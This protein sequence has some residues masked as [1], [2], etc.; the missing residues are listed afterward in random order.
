MVCLCVFNSF[1]RHHP[2]ASG[3]WRR[4]PGI[5]YCRFSIIQRSLFLL[6]LQVQARNLKRQVGCY[7]YAGIIFYFFHFFISCAKPA[8]QIVYLYGP[9][10]DIACQKVIYSLQHTHLFG[11]IKIRGNLVNIVLGFFNFIPDSG[12]FRLIYIQFSLRQG[13]LF[14]SDLAL[15]F[16]YIILPGGKDRC[17]VS[18]AVSR[19]LTC[20]S[21]TAVSSLAS[22]SPFL[23]DRLSVTGISATVPATSKAMSCVCARA[24]LPVP[25]HRWKWYP[26]GRCKCL[27]LRT[28]GRVVIGQ[29]QPNKE[30]ERTDRHDSRKNFEP[31]H[32]IS[33]EPF[34]KLCAWDQL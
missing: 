31:F 8:S 7:V 10:F 15:C 18:R 11:E 33:P 3:H 19:P 2:N 23:T 5:F 34:F 20:L 22:T 4:T 6:D 21:H 28:A 9:V 30:K 24:K 26:S 32:N 12:Y 17:A 29:K 25:V 1:L 14:N 27:R 13:I 16:G